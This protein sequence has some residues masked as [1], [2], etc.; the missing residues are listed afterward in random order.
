MSRV[1]QL[2]REQIDFDSRL[3]NPVQWLLW[4][5]TAFLVVVVVFG[6]RPPEVLEPL[7]LASVFLPG[8]GAVILLLLYMAMGPL[9]PE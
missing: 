9:G 2:I 5:S 1:V 3:R 7:F 8:L 4:L 6:W